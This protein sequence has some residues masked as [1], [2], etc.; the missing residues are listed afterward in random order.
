MCFINPLSVTTFKLSSVLARNHYQRLIGAFSSFLRCHFISC[1]RM[2]LSTVAH[3]VQIWNLVSSRTTIPYERMILTYLFVRSL[4]LIFL[5]G[6]FIYSLRLLRLLRIRLNTSKYGF[7]SKA[8][9]TTLSFSLSA[10]R[11]ETSAAYG[12]F[13]FQHRVRLEMS[14]NA[15][16]IIMTTCSLSSDDASSRQRHRNEFNIYST[17]EKAYHSGELRDRIAPH[18]YG[19]F[20]VNGVDFLILDLV[21]VYM[22]EI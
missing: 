5:L 14:G 21:C 8:C 12:L 7:T 3:T 4:I 15:I 17:L 13:A 16:L 20:K 9:R 2:S 11:A 6:L 1:L 22:K 10:L 18:G 19:A